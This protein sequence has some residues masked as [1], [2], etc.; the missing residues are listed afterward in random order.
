MRVRFR[1]VAC[2]LDIL[3]NCFSLLHLRQTLTSLP[4]TLDDTYARILCNIDEQFNHCNRDILKI[5]QWLTFSARPLRLEE[6]AEILA[7]DVDQTPRF[8]PERRWPEPRDILRI[9]SSLITITMHSSDASVQDDLNEDSQDQDTYSVAESIDAQG[10]ITYVRLAH[11]S[12][13][14]YLV[15]DRVRQGMAS[16]YSIREIESHGILA[17]D[18]IAY[19]LQFDEPDPLTSESL[20]LSPLAHYAAKFWVNHAK[21]AER[22]PIKSTTLL[23]FELLISDRV[24]FLNWIRIA[25]PDYFGRWEKLD[26]GLED[27]A[28]PLYYASQAGLFEQ[29]KMLI[30]RRMDVNVP[31]GEYGNPLQVASHLGYKD[32]VQVLLDNGADVNIRGGRWINALQAASFQ[33]HLDILQVLLENGADVNAEGDAYY[34]NALQAASLG[35][36]EHIIPFLIES[37]ANVN[38]RGGYYG[39][40]LQAAS[41]LGRDDRVQVLLDNGADVNAQGG[42]FG[43]ALQAA[44]YYGGAHDPVWWVGWRELEDVILQMSFEIVPDIHAKE[45]GV[46]QVL[47]DNGADINAQGGVFGSALQAASTTSEHT[48]V[49]CLLIDSGADVNMQGGEY[50]SALVAACSTGSETAVKVL[51]DRNADVNVLGGNSRRNAL[52]VASEKGYENIV[53]MLLDKGANVNTYAARSRRSAL[54]LASRNGHQN[55]VKMLLD[56]GADVNGC[57]DKIWGSALQYASKRGHK[58]I[59]KMLVAKGAVIPSERGRE[60]DPLAKSNG[61]D[62]EAIAAPRAHD[63]TSPTP[64]RNEK[65]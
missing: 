34:G 64:E 2:Q 26:L 12:V 30:E 57:N 41:Y 59:M 56:Q 35:E 55:V 54:Q 19:L 47:L 60:F 61:P 51:L 3:G 21:H 22:G 44:S 33:G 17:E 40:A 62:P 65:V 10:P 38:A 7:I 37:G 4:K 14:E 23:S 53:M 58:N 28:S 42:F 48:D 45:K 13:K 50:G 5:L 63:T 31:G 46:V 16:H 32:V 1:W 18:C 9:C 29:V 27:L 25:N 8:D 11:F 52:Q 24:G 49:I 15:S 20:A 6:V 39:N 36:H 43:N